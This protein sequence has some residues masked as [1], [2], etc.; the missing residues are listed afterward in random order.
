VAR[1]G[2]N[3]FM[4]LL[5]GSPADRTAW[6]MQRPGDGQTMEQLFASADAATLEAECERGHRYG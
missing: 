6:I 1:T 5:P 2:E 3:Q 4:V